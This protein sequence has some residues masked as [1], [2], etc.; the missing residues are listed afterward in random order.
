MT[1]ARKLVLP[2]ALL[3]GVVASC[4]RKDSKPKDVEPKGF[5]SFVWVIGLTNSDSPVRVIDGIIVKR[6][7]K[8]ER[9][10]VRPDGSTNETSGILPEP[11]YEE[12]S[13]NMGD[14]AA[15]PSDHGAATYFGPVDGHHPAVIQRVLDF[16]LK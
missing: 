12:L 4:E 3:F 10:V 13:R 11:I 16:G 14:E 8:Y 9:K 1:T 5:D 2:V 7:H 6:S 15:F